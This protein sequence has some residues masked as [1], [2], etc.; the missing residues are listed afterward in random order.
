MMDTAKI[1][2]ITQQLL[3]VVIVM[4]VMFFIQEI[5]ES[6][7]L[8]TALPEW[9][10]I[11]TLFFAVSTRYFFGVTAA[12]VV[13]L[14]EDV[15]LGVPTIG[16]HAIIYTLSAFTIISIRYHFRQHSVVVQSLIIGV[17]VAV[18]VVF[19]MIYSSVVYNSPAYF[20][21]LLSIPASM[22]TWP[23]VYVFFSFFTFQHD[24]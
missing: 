2:D 16:L 3:V 4:T 8:Q 21:V 9:P 11:M 15:F 23:L 1:M 22:L 20:W 13:G 5:P 10:Y 24:R 19:L 7:V 14:I 17:L 12:F 6:N 18:K